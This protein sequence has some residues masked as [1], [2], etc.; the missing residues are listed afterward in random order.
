M[1]ATSSKFKP[2]TEYNQSLERGYQLLPFRFIRLDEKRYVATN[3]AG[4]YIVLK[5]SDLYRMARKKLMPGSEIYNNLKSKHFLY[6]SDSKI[7]IELLAMK[8]RTKMLPI[9][10]FT[11]LHMFVTT[12]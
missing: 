9:T 12:L 8:V 2:L 10:N 3:V 5:Q 6:D 1:P 11:G 7:A 4:E